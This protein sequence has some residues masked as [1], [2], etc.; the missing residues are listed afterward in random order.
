[1]FGRSKRLVLLAASL[2]L[3]A[4]LSSPAFA[5]SLCSDDRATGAVREIVQNAVPEWSVDLAADF[6]DW[7]RVERVKNLTKITAVSSIRAVSYDKDTVSRGITR[8]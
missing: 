6:G 8:S 5:S 4:V 1:M 7:A 3:A 2:T